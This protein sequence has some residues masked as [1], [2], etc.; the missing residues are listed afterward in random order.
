MLTLLWKSIWNSALQAK[1]QNKFCPPL[2]EEWNQEAAGF[3]NK[4][5][6]EL[7]EKQVFEYARKN[8]ATVTLFIR[9]PF[10]ERIVT[11]QKVTAISFISD[12]GGLLGLFMGFSFVSAVEILFHACRVS[13]CSLLL[14]FSFVGKV[15]VKIQIIYLKHMMWRAVIVKKEKG[16]KTWGC[17]V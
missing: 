16:Q 14:S 13:L 15:R 6:A 5:I 4:S 8:I 17:Y 9:D 12:V 3:E 2:L 1:D 11:S 10:A 7:F